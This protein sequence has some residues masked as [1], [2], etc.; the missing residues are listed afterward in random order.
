MF[1]LMHLLIFSCEI[2]NIMTTF[3]S[4]SP[5]DLYD[6]P[7]DL[8]GSISYSFHLSIGIILGGP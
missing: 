8:N 5:S 6:S 7:N 1:M 2:P 3:F 4:Y